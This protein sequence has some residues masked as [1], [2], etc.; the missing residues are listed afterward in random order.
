VLDNHRAAQPHY[1]FRAIGTGNAVPTG[2]FLPASRQSSG[3]LLKVHLR[4]IRLMRV[5][6]VAVAVE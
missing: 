3:V 1:I 6:I 2:I 4:L 5:A